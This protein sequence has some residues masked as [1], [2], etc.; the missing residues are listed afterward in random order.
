MKLGLTI[1]LVAVVTGAAVSIQGRTNSPATPKVT[2]IRTP[3]DGI[4]PQTVLDSHGVLHVIYFRGDASAGDIEYVR[5]DTDAKKFS[6]PIRVNSEAGSAVAIG[7]VRG[8]QLAVGRNGRVY[9]I[10]FGP[11]SQAGESKDAMPVFFSRLN[12]S[13]TAFEPQRN[14]M[15]W[16][17]NLEK[18]TDASMWRGPLMMAKRLHAKFRFHQRNSGLADAAVCV[19]SQIIAGHSLFCT[20][21]QPKTSIGI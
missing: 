7:T 5:R 19:L 13:H 3:H 10:W 21:P 1:A 17:R 11:Q 8:P 2:L 12:D 15:Q 6:H 16:A 18:T 14:L 9:V 4:Q 20:A